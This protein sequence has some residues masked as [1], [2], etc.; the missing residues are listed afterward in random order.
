MVIGCGWRAGRPRD[1]MRWVSG[2]LVLLAGLTAVGRSDAQTL[3]SQQTDVL[4]DGNVRTAY[5][6]SNHDLA[7]AGNDIRRVV[8][9]VHG[10]SR[11]NITFERVMEEVLARGLDTETLVFAPQFLIED[12]VTANALG[13]EAL[14]W[15]GGWRQGDLSR[16]NGLGR[17]SSF[18]VVDRVVR[19]LVNNNPQVSD[20]VI[21]GHSA[22]GQYA[23]RFAAASRLQQD[24]EALVAGIQVRYVPSNPS[25]TVYMNNRRRVAGSVEE[26]AVPDS[27][28]CP[29]YDEYRYGLSSGLNSYVT[30]AGGADQVRAQYPSRDVRYLMGELDNDAS[31]SSLDRSCEANL[32]GAQRLERATIYY[33]HLRDA[34]GESAHDTHVLAVS[35]DIGHTSRVFT[36]DCGLNFLLDIGECSFVTPTHLSSNVDAASG[37][38]SLTWRDRSAEETGYEVLRSDDAGTSFSPLASL[39]ANAESYTDSTSLAATQYRYR[40]RAL[41]DADRSAVSNTTIANPGANPVPPQPAPPPPSPPSPAPD[42]SSGGGA[43]ALL[44]VVLAGFRVARRPRS[45]GIP[46]ARTPVGSR[47]V[48]EG[49]SSS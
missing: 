45:T 11:T 35:P 43:V 23:Q 46:A 17:I 32:Q 26:F 42:S 47:A 22:G 30:A 24:L 29:D 28:A 3:F 33:H 2:L 39:P 10:A 6:E 25:S 12:D 34:F 7:V 5:F 15:A 36:T 40:V 4:V 8:V 48:D 27:T 1:R 9:L 37:A 16:D 31:S 44:L 20:V 41:K 14:F 13:P 21:A 19:E 38:V 18:E 49:S